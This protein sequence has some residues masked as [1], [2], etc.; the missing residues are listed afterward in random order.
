MADCKL[1]SRRSIALII[2]ILY[3]FN[4]LLLFFY[5]PGSIDQGVINKK[6]KANITG[7]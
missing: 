6:L 4:L 3:I 1:S 7:G 2:I 5:T